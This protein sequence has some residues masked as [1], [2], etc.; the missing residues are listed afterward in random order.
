M[1]YIVEG[2]NAAGKS[3]LCA[4]LARILRVPTY[5][6]LGRKVS[7]AEG[8]SGGDLQRQS[9]SV[10]LFVEQI[11][12]NHDFVIDRY[13]PTTYVFKGLNPARPPLPSNLAGGPVAR[14]LRGRTFETLFHVRADVDVLLG[15]LVTRGERRTRDSVV[16]EI[17]AYDRLFAELRAAGIPVVVVDGTRGLEMEG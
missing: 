15:R 12:P 2:P 9:L 11:G 10:D 1:I 16:A 7:Q 13:W 4:H 8:C 6:D 17:E 14:A 5:V 3:T